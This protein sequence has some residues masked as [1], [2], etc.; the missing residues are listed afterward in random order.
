M[1]N[2]K[3]TWTNGMQFVGESDSNHGIVL[4]TVPAVG[5]HESGIKPFELFLIG[6]AG[7]TA[8]DTISILKKK[9]QNVVRFAVDVGAERS[10]EHPKVYTKIHVH[11]KV[12]GYN[13]KEDAVHRA[14]ELSE[15]TYCP[16]YATLKKSTPI[17]NEIE[18]IE[19]SEN[20][21]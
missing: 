17:T 15:E 14:V 8:M 5:G 6:L 16:A 12:E 2:A 21:S 19:L 10:D 20:A 9:R 4:D 1:A 11:Y 7:C 13:L 18:I 3:V